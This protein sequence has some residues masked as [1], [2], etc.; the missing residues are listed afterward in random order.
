MTLPGRTSTGND[1]RYGFNGHEKD[2]EI[3]G[4]GN[5]YDFGNFGYDSRL[6]R[7]WQIDPA[8]PKYPHQS[9]YVTFNNSPIVVYDPD[10]FEGIIVSGQPGTHGNKEHFL[11]NGLIKA[12]AAQGKTK[13]SGEK[14]TWIIFNDGSKEMGHNP[15]MLAKYK[16]EAANLGITVLEVSDVDEII[17]YVNDKDVDG[18]SRLWFGNDR[19]NDKISSFY[20][21][22]H[23]TL[24][25]L[26]PGYKSNGSIDVDDFD[27]EAFDS[28]CWINVVGGCRTAV[29]GNLW[30]EESVVDDF[31]EIVDEKSTVN[32]SSVK[33]QYSGGEVPDKNLVKYTDENGK[34]VNG[35]IVTKKGKK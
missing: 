2:D 14:V 16:K 8:S 11:K 29:E 26:E 10:G 5:H 21:V 3:K 27:S 17:N 34:K 12:K 18:N 23:A 20:Y 33:V 7:R 15:A 24:G 19:D 9:T 28:G 4:E 6:G 31:V 32:G 22:G 25:D 30:F 35:E 1:Y 13:K